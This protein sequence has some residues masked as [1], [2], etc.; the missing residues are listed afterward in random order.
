MLTLASS[1]PQIRLACLTPSDAIS[2]SAPH[3]A[4]GKTATCPPALDH[5]SPAGQVAGAPRRP[6]APWNHAP[7]RSLLVGAPNM[8]TTTG[9]ES[10][11]GGKPSGES[12]SAGGHQGGVQGWCPEMNH[13]SNDEPSRCTLH[14]GTSCHPAT[15]R[16]K[17]RE[18]KARETALMSIEGEAT[19]E[20][21]TQDGNRDCR[22]QEWKPTD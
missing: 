3:S 7:S 15:M 6:L 4:A 21:P 18:R 20:R 11:G 5:G 8:D 12:R 14:R 22:H 19:P 1:A 10:H 13:E 2:Q 16:P 17:A 9:S